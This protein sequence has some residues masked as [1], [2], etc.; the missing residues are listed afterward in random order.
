MYHSPK[1]MWEI[2]NQLAQDCWLLS[3]DVRTLVAGPLARGLVLDSVSSPC[4]HQE[5]RWGI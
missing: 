3:P 2:P 1:S 5:Q 4:A